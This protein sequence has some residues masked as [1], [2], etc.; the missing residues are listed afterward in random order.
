MW[1][2]VDFTYGSPVHPA[3]CMAVVAIDHLDRIRDRARRLLETNRALVN[4]FLADHP[5]IVCEPSQF[6]TTLFPRLRSGSA[7]N[8]VTLLREQFDTSVVPGDFFEQPQHFRIGFCGSTET[9]RGG[10]ERLSGALS[11]FRAV[12]S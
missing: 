11:A 6:G 9:V 5:A 1:Q 7:A 4:T 12:A 8:F 3:E 2:I 10:L